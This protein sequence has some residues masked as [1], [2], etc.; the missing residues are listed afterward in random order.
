MYEFFPN[1]TICYPLPI[2]P[3]I[4]TGTLVLDEMQLS[5]DVNFDRKDM[6]YKGFTDLGKYTPEDQINQRGDHALVFLF[7]PFRDKWVQTL[8]AF[9][10]KGCANTAG[11]CIN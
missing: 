8:G 2:F 5:E 6:L 11:F 9:L 3:F 4:L 10:S 7:Q 1:I